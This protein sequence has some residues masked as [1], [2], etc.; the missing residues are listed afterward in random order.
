M[1]KN[2][3]ALQKRIDT[4]IEQEM[5]QNLVDTGIVKKG[6]FLW[7]FDREGCQNNHEDYVETIQHLL[8]KEIDMHSFMEKD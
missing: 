3:N 8:S 6:K 2:E 7:Q 4:L 5:C 1:L